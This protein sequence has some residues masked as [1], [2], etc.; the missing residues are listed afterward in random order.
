MFE[1]IP[2]NNPDL[3]LSNVCSIINPTE[4]SRNTVGFQGMGGSK[5]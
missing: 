5:N 1:F 2:L 4:K 3:I